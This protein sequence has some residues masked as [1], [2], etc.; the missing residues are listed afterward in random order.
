VKC[1]NDITYYFHLVT[2]LEYEVT[3]FAVIEQ[4]L[5]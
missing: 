3:I 1:V 2:P 4:L 5:K